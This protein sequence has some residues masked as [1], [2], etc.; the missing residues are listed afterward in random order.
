MKGWRP[1]RLGGRLWGLPCGL[2]RGSSCPVVNL[3]HAGFFL[4]FNFGFKL[5][6]TTPMMSTLEE[7]ARDRQNR[8]R[9]ADV[10]CSVFSTGWR[11]PA[12]V[13]VDATWYRRVA[14]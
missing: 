10:G 5:W 14:S 2:W 8:R 9:R 13:D 4:I 6:R 3:G 7:R 12:S 11:E 1:G